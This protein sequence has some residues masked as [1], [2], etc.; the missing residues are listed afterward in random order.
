MTKIESVYIH[1]PFCKK[2]CS[3]CDFPK[4]YT[5]DKWISPYLESLN[6]EIK[7][8]YQN[9][10]LKTLYIGGG[11][12]TCLDKKN[13]IKL[14]EI[15]KNFKFQKDFEFTIECNV[16]DID[17][18]LLKVLKKY[19]VN[20]L[21]IGVQTFNK[22]I[23]KKLNRCFNIDYVE[24]INLA[25]KYFSNISVDLM[26][27]LP[28]A[29]LKDLQDDLNQ[30][31]SLNIPHISCYSL[32]IEPHTL[33]Y[34]QGIKIDEE[35]DK[36]MYDLINKVLKENN[37]I[38]YETS[39]YGKEGYFSKHNLVYWNNENYYG[40]GLGASGYIKNIRYTNTKKIDEYLKGNY[41]LEKEILTKKDEMIYEMILG[42]R[43]QIGVNE[44][45]FY[46][47]YGQTIEEVFLIDS[48]LKEKKLLKKNGFIY[49]PYEYSYLANEI[50]VYFV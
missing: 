25:K 32:M 9:E 11:T 16:Q 12:P 24:K 2:I 30:I 13:L 37:Y 6:K 8:Y 27:S 42:L 41:C 35:L 31:L 19:Q 5:I 33:F 44:K 10:K 22:D 45:V 34:N 4:M 18:N 3:Y 49:I 17:E 28:G 36:K 7:K 40:F 26:Y 23:L 39:N 50:L 29:T 15:T 14:L 38:H 46:K 47:K 20:R 21:S 48:L 43:K 1:I